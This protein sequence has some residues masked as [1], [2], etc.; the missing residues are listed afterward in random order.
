MLK[1]YN[2]IVGAVTMAPLLA[3]IAGYAADIQDPCAVLPKRNVAV[4]VTSATTTVLVT[5][6]VG[7]QIFVCGG[8][9]SN[10]NTATNQGT[11]QFEYGAAPT[12]TSP[13]VLSG[14]IGAGNTTA[15][16]PTPYALGNGAGSML[17]VPANNALCV[18]TVGSS[19]NVQ[20]FISVIQ[21]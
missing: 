2:L 17:S 18:V 11:F 1:S 9:L 8:V 4:A 6:T 15:G 21:N 7:Q 14:A 20:G 16:T 3:P 12:C 13:T 10:L 5:A 19:V